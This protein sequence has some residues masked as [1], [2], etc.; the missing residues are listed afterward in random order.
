MS[1][2]DL[3]TAAKC[4]ELS[5]RINKLE[6][7]IQELAVRLTDH[8]NM[9]V[10]YSHDYLPNFDVDTTING[11]ELTTK[12]RIENREDSRT[13]TL[14]D[15]V[16][17]TV[18]I[19]VIPIDNY[20]YTIA[21]T[22]NESV[23][24]A[25]L[26]IHQPQIQF[27]IEKLEGQQYGF[28]ILFDDMAVSAVLDLNNF[29][30]TGTETTDA[31]FDVNVSYLFN[32]LG[33]A[34]TI[35]GVTKSDTVY[36]D[37]DVINRFG[38]GGGGTNIGGDD[39]GCQQ[40]ADALQLELA[41]ILAAIAA[42]QAQVTQ[43]KEVVTVEVEGTALTKFDCPETDPDSGEE[44]DTF[45]FEDYKLATL[46]AIHEQLLWMNLNQLAMFERICEAGSVLAF[47]DWW[48]V[49]LGSK[50]PQIVC[51]FRKGTTS[52]Y[53][54]LSIPHPAN[55]D[56]PT[57][58]L[59]PSYTKGNW[60]GMVICRDNSKFIVNAVNSGEA[61]VMCDA[62]ISLI[63]SEWLEQPPRVYIGE[64][65]GQAVG[66]DVMYPTTIE[67]FESGQQNMIPN[68]RVRVTKPPQI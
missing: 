9:P 64:R 12:V 47:P 63:D 53:H 65:K 31:D 38:G 15:S 39:V 54:S 13:I 18:A 26:T 21:V 51:S 46:P 2:G 25:A 62:A 49:R 22:V 5:N 27:G 67:Y 48:Q 4:A 14:P 1:C 41:E 7:S 3:C 66:V 10:P 35:D 56:E 57:S 32:L 50:V 45:E 19:E 44:S 17:P 28:G 40:I 58:A 23:A 60:Q 36:I 6:Q 29:D 16:V 43:V 8:A 61:A 33:V 34:V 37:A 20:N 24:E 59:L 11:N 42:V 30:P 55:T 52:T 68:W